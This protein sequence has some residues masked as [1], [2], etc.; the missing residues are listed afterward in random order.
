M[1]I[2]FEKIKIFCP[3][4]LLLLCAFF[5]TSCSQNMP[6]LSQSDYSVIF[7]YAEDEEYPSARLSV[8]MSAASD[9]RRF[10]RIRIKSLEADYIWDTSEIACLESDNVQWAG[11]TNLVAP[12]NKKLPLGRYE[13]S[14]FNADEKEC[15]V[16]LDITYDADFYD[17]LFSALPE[18]M[19]DKKGLEKI[20][21]Y[22]K[23][24]LLLYFGDR[25][26]EFKT[27]RGIW[28]VYREAETY[29][30]I[31]YTRDGRVI[32]IGPEKKVTPEAEN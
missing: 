9:V 12:E 11:C 7:D 5:I 10:E 22:G 4:I 15:K 31:W 1:K 2:L 23:D 20:A 19:A 17:V 28:N 14:Y 6:E 16:V 30:L 25:N 32:C 29:N 27:T 18:V 26:T 24:K 3:H 8:F 21:I 13:V